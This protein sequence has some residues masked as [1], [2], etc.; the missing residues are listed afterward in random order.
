MLHTP[1]VWEYALAIEHENAY[2]RVGPWRDD[3]REAADDWN[4]F[5]LAVDDEW[6]LHFI[7]M[8]HLIITVVNRTV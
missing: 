6:Y 8:R 5:L 4:S 1:R 2:I 7:G 3:R